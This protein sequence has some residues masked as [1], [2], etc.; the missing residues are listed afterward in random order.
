MKRRIVALLLMVMVLL[1]GCNIMTGNIESLLKAPQP[2]NMQAG[3]SAVVNGTLGNAIKYV[4]PLNGNY[5]NSVILNDLDGDGRREAIIFY[6]SVNNAGLE[7]FANFAVF[8]SYEDGTW[9]LIKQVQG[10]SMQIDYVDF[11]DFN[12]D[13][14]KDMLIGWIQNDSLRELCAYDMYSQSEEAM[15]SD[16]YND[17]RMFYNGSAFFI[18]NIYRDSTTSKGSAKISTVSGNMLKTVATCEIYGG[19]ENI[20]SVQYNKVDMEHK[21]IIID[22]KS[23]NSMITQ[24][25]LWED[26]KLTNPFY[27]SEQGLNS[28]LVRETVFTCQDIDGDGFIEIPFTTPLPAVPSIATNKDISTTVITGWGTINLS[29]PGVTAA[30]VLDRDFFCIMN[31]AQKFYYIIPSEW[32]GKFSA[33]YNSS[34]QSLSFYYIQDEI[35]SK[36]FSLYGM[37][38]EQYDARKEQGTWFELRKLESKVFA[39]NIV[40]EL[41]TEQSVFMGNMAEHRERLTYII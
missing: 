15:F 12:G 38:E 11:R 40:S 33:T 36:L 14:R 20:V 17:S 24:I 26:N 32:I 16:M 3:L 21:A 5:K 6:L 25:L 18:L 1:S 34:D 4:S 27:D 31:S 35:Y 39:I 8:T 23:G 29:S 13:S 41:S 37:S 7:S 2:N 9:A 10:N 28:A 19:Y 22:A 30:G